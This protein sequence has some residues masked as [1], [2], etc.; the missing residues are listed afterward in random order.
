MWLGRCHGKRTEVSPPVSISVVELASWLR[1]SVANLVSVSSFKCQINKTCFCHLHN[2]ISWNANPVSLWNNSRLPQEHFYCVLACWW[3]KF[4]LFRHCIPL[5]F[6]VSV[7][8]IGGVNFWECRR[9]RKFNRQCQNFKPNILKTT[10]TLISFFCCC[11]CFLILFS[12]P[13]A[14]S[15]QQ[16]APGSNMASSSSVGDNQLQR[17]IRDLHGNSVVHT[18]N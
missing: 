9:V 7:C 1:L 8:F 3:H 2:C 16:T 18:F 6:V 14:E 11:C 15:P 5:Y 17:I 13:S 10:M 4:R 12:F